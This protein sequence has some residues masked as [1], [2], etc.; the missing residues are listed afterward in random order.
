MERGPQPPDI[1]FPLPPTHSVPWS[2]ASPCT[3]PA[4]ALEGGQWKRK[5]R[6]KSVRRKGLNAPCLTEETSL[7]FQEGRGAPGVQQP[8]L[9]EKCVPGEA[10]PLPLRLLAPSGS[11]QTGTRSCWI[12]QRKARPEPLKHE[13]FQLDWGGGG[14]G[15]WHSF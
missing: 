12:S 13:W 5:G 11:G 15:S 9:S 1:T 8:L 10:A 7:S 3:Q 4:V 14:G 2:P 6:A